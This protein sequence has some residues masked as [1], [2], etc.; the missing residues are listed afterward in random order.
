MMSAYYLPIA[1]LLGALSTWFFA[2]AVH[3]KKLNERIRKDEKAIERSEQQVI[4][5]LSRLPIGI[6]AVSAGNR[7]LVFANP[8]AEELLMG[9]SPMSILLMDTDGNALAGAAHPFAGTGKSNRNAIYEL[10]DAG[11]R[12]RYL[13]I[14]ST[15]V[16]DEGS[17]I[18]EIIFMIQD[19]TTRIE[20]E[21]ALEQS[22]RLEALGT[23]TSGVA[24]DFNNMLTP[25]V[26]GLDV[27][28]RD[29]GIS[30]TSKRAI[31]RALQATGR[32]TTLVHRLLAF[33]REQELQ[34]RKVDLKALV[35]GAYDL[36][37]RKLGPDINTYVIARQSITV[38]TDPNQLELAMLALM[39][40][41]RDAMPNG[42]EMTITVEP[43]EIAQED[44]LPAGRYALISV[45]DNGCG[46][47]ESVRQHAVDPFFTTKEM[48]EGAGLGLSM[49][50]GLAAQSGGRLEIQSEPG[51]GTRIDIWLPA[52][53]GEMSPTLENA[54]DF[55]PTKHG[56]ILVVDDEDMVR[57]ATAAMLID[58]GHTV[59][60]AASGPE[61]ITTIRR[62][63]NI[64]AV[65]ADHL[66]PGM[67]GGA[68]THEIW[69]F[70]ASMPVLLISGYVQPEALPSDIPRLA[71]PFRRVDLAREVEKML[72]REVPVP[73][74]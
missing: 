70:N 47:T 52:V 74:A 35:E 57:N 66:M 10:T 40:N 73:A 15:L 14:T 32:A 4:D 17:G 26:G 31:D 50:D 44:D 51:R 67:T 42:G 64:D 25:I 55:V 56:N 9:R 48:G 45:T 3:N 62:Q 6:I 20:T 5:I 34:T 53:A 7:E 60:H 38:E 58:L 37:G 28:R 18:S 61:A 22:H 39:A 49:V 33:S 36:F 30:D 27:V 8:Q 21:H 1:L 24:H 65:V 23:L 11:K 63:G 71:K 54:E 29:E 2:A 46:M 16:S 72:T 19:E 41:S 43:V 59:V 13:S 69:D 12:K 68:M